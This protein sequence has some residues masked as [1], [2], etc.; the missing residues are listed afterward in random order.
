LDARWKRKNEEIN[1]KE[2]EELTPKKPKVGGSKPSGSQLMVVILGPSQA[3]KQQ[4]VTEMVG[5]LWELVEE[6][7][8]L[9]KVTRGMSGLRVQI[10]QQNAKLIRLGERQS[11][12][13]EKAIKRGLGL[14]SE[15]EAG[16]MEKEGAEKDKGKG[17]GAKGNEEMMKDDRSS[18]EE[19]EEEE[20]DARL[21]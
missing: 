2:D 4:P 21:D 9:T 5:L 11:Y 7:R 12:L 18:E 6:V 19:E 10:Y 17:K 8:E 14:G 20:N 16:E 15:T 13:A 3:V 1:S